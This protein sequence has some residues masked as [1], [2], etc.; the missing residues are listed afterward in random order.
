MA[1]TYIEAGTEATWDHGRSDH[2]DVDRQPFGIAYLKFDLRG[3]T[4]PV[5][6]ATLTLFCSN[7]SDDGGTIFPGLD[8]SWVEGTG[9]GTDASSAGR[10][11]L[12]WTDVDTNGDGDVNGRDSSPFVPDFAHPV[13][14]LGSLSAG[15]AYT[16]DVTAAFQR[17]PGIYT[18]AIRSGSTNG[19]T[20]S[21][22]EN[23]SG[24]QRPVLRLTAESAAL[25]TN[26]SGVR[27]ELTSARLGLRRLGTGTETLKLAGRFLIPVP[28]SPGLDLV[29]NGTRISVQDAVGNTVASAALPGGAFDGTSGWQVN[30]NRSRW[31]FRDRSKPAIHGGITKMLVKDDSSRT[32]GQIGVLVAGKGGSYAAIPGAGSF[33]VV[34]EL[35]DAAGGGGAS[36]CGEMT[37]ASGDCIFNS[38]GTTLKCQ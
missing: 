22:R 32:P 26:L 24:G 38:N 37:F 2:V 12:K 25:C 15:H 11:G 30:G 17:G 28:F 29:R 33:H 5:G 34:I 27:N 3:L 23:S 1:D 19:A 7:G 18:V 13:A 21:S 36:Q 35:N 31:I 10:P 14:S 20:Y 4:G 16:V 8:S 6:Q 9:N